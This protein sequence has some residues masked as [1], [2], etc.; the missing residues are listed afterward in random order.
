M[1]IN[2][3]EEIASEI[4]VTRERVRQIQQL[5]ARN[6]INHTRKL[7]NNELQLEIF[8]ILNHYGKDLSL[9]TLKSIL[10]KKRILGEF[11]AQIVV[12]ENKGRAN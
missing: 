7:Y 5:V 10:V 1:N 9:K 2:T 11:S 12:R 8:D 4:N 3:L 6:F